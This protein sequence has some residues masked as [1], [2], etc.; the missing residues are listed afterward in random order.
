MSLICIISLFFH[1]VLSYIA[2]RQ[3]D[4]QTDG[5]TNQQTKSNTQSLS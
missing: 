3:T 2:H 5:V 4:G 1:N